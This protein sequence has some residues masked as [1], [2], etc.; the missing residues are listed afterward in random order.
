M[1]PGSGC[2]TRTRQLRQRLAADAAR[3]AGRTDFA[4]EDVVDAIGFGAATTGRIRNVAE[5]TLSY[6]VE[7]DDRRRLSARLGGRYVGERLDTDFTDFLNVADFPT[8]RYQAED[9]RIE[10]G[11]VTLNGK[12]APQLSCKVRSPSPH[13]HSFHSTSLDCGSE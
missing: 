11:R 6:G 13:R 1:R 4:A 5:L 10:D 9:V 3:F 2:R 12:R 7:Y 8:G